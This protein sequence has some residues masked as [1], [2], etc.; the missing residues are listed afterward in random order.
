MSLRLQELERDGE[1]ALGAVRDLESLARFK[2]QYLGSRGKLKQAMAWLKDASPL[3]RPVLGQGLNELKKRLEGRVAELEGRM[4]VAQ[5]RAEGPALDVTEPGLP[6]RLGRTHAITRVM[7]ELIE[8]FAR[9]GFEVVTG[10][11]IEDERHNFVA[12]NI[13][14]E[15]LARDPNDNFYLDEKHLLRTQT[16]TM[17]VRTMESRKPPLR[18]I[19]PG[20]VYRPDTHD[21]THTSMFHQI[22]GLYVDRGVTMADLKTTLVQFAH[23]MFGTEV[24]TRFRPSYFPFTEP[25]AEMDVEMELRGEKRWVE[26]LGCGMVDPAVFEAVGYDPEE[27]TG[28]AFGMGVERVVMRRYGVADIRWL[29]END[30]RFLAKI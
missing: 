21:A 6:A 10:P 16:S 23:A 5:S 26:L 17:Q 3:E 14:P 22:E 25:S 13:P 29:F 11:E 20:R 1:A 19:A 12:L 30:V 27:W 7:D 2:S 28:F 15:H 4:G 8:V 18:I 9:M 24:K